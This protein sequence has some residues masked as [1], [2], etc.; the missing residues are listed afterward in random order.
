MP[1]LKLL[2]LDFVVG[3]GG[4]GIA[5]CKEALH[6]NVLNQTVEYGSHLVTILK[7]NQLH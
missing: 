7:L 2:F 1:L 3:G 4:D 5:M 6:L